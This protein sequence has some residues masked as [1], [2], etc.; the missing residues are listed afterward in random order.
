MPDSDSAPAISRTIPTD[1]AS[2]R[3]APTAAAST[4]YAAPS[5]RNICTRWRR[6]VP[7]ARAVP[8]SPR[9]SAASITKTRKMSRMPAE[10]VKRAEGREQREERRA[11]LVGLLE[12]VALDLLDRR[13]SS[14]VVGSSW[15]VT[16][17]V[18][19]APL[20]VVAVVGH[21]D[22]LHPVAD[23]EQPLG[24]RQR[25]QQRARCRSRCRRTGRCRAR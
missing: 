3:T 5:K 24:L 25:H 15:D 6:W 7:I 20:V 11:L 8:I 13:P 21:E 16:S 18:R 23:E 14:R 4:S 9:R 19:A 17:S 2:P 22:V 10:I 1:N 12:P